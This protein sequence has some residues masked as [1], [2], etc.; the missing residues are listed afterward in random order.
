MKL[1]KIDCN[2][3]TPRRLVSDKVL[4][5]ESEKIEIGGFETVPELRAYSGLILQ[6]L[7]DA[8]SKKTFFHAINENALVHIITK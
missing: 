1:E 3:Y 6:S 8:N 2:D 7:R 4:H 5:G